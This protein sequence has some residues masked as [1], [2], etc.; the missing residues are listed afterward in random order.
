MKNLKAYIKDNPEKLDAVT[1]S[2]TLEKRHLAFLR[3][4]NINLSKLVR[5]YIDLLIGENK[6]EKP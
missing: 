3:K 4:L 6:N 1:T 5:D 2:L